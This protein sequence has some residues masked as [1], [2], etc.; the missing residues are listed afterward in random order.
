[1]SDSFPMAISRKHFGERHRELQV[2]TCIWRTPHA[3][4][5]VR[6]WRTR[7][8]A[9]L[10]DGETPGGVDLPGAVVEEIVRNA[11]AR[12][13]LGESLRAALARLTDADV[14]DTASITAFGSDGRPE[15]VA[16]SD[17]IALKA[18]QLQY[19]LA[20][21]PCLEVLRTDQM[22]LVPDLTADC[23]WP[24]WTPSAAGLGIGASLSMHLV[25][26]TALGALNLYSLRPRAFAS[27]DIDAAE[28]VAAQASV[29][30][31]YAQSQKE[32]E[33]AID[34]RRVIGQAQGMLMARYGLTPAQAFAMLRRYSQD[35]NLRIS[36][37]AQ[38]FTSTGQLPGFDRRL[39][40]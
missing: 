25:A 8:E 12:R 2:A 39:I 18:D 21:G 3:C 37:L 32:L 4:I 9:D 1:M 7:S 38:E 19:E 22:S 35:R 15:S 17:D 31:A 20:E 29:V 40:R 6:G 27:H 33:R 34:S 36:A 14:C 5:N 13:D 10:A 11:V 28:V 26:D 24:R 30:L 16:F 23:R